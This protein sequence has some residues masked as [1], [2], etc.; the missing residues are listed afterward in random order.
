MTLIFTLL[1]LGAILMF[2]GTLLSARI[3]GIVAFLCWIG[4]VILGYRD[5]EFQTGNLILGAVLMGSMIAAFWRLKFFAKS[6]FA[7]LFIP[8]PTVGVLGAVKP[9]LLNRSGVAITQLGPSGAAF[10]NGKRV[11][12]ITEGALIDQG[13]SVQVVAVRGMRVVVREM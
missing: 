12:V 4:A 6:R 8:R 1:A 10:I 13:A 7:G 5:F 2:L 3:T 9:G 11:D